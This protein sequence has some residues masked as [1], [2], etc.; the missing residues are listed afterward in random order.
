MTKEYI[1]LFK[2]WEDLGFNFKKEDGFISFIS[3]L[4]ND[5]SNFENN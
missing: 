5:N 2:M 1:L 3:L 4:K